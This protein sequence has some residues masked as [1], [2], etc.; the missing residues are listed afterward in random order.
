MAM[1]RGWIISLCLVLLVSVSAATQFKVG[2]TGQWKVPDQNSKSYNQ[3]AQGTRFKTGDTLAFTYQPDQDSVLLVNM[4]AYNSCDTNSPID[5]FADGN[6]VF[7][8][9][10]SGP[11]YFISGNKDN[12]NKGE[13]VHIVVMGSRNN[14]TNGSAPSSSP[15]SPS[16]GSAQVTPDTNSPPPPGTNG[17]SNNF[18][19]IVVAFGAAF[20]S[21]LSV[22][23]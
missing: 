11:F 12:C 21:I 23:V 14:S 4:N 7:T 13:K 19:G 1:N 16:S 18:G 2:G 15:P 3:W 10:K 6:T 22:L 20:G 9:T 17:A 8:F 5:H